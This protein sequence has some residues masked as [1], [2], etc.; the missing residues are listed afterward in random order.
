MA[1][2]AQEVSCGQEECN[3]DD[4][5]QDAQV[6]GNVLF[7]ISFAQKRESILLEVHHEVT[8]GY[9]E[10]QMLFDWTEVALSDCQVE[11]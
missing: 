3:N 7:L 10:V 9:W 1:E 6:F 8:A 11:V 4:G 5:F 2:P